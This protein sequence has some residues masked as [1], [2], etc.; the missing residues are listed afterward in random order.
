MPQRFEFLSPD[1]FDALANV[2]M[3]APMVTKKK[4]TPAAPQRS[5]SR[6]LVIRLNDKERDAMERVSKRIGMSLSETVRY[7]IRRAEEEKLA[8]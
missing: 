1:P 4:K 7:L 3:M 2:L 5:R 6:N 8:L